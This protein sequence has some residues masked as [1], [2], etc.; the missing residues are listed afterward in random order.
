M[1]L[2][3]SL[4]AAL[5]LVAGAALADAPAAKPD[6]RAACGGDVIRLCPLASA[7]KDR[8]ECMKAHWADI[9]PTCKAAIKVMQAEGAP[10][11]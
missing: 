11:P 8:R 7:G 2:A 10:K 3:L 1:K 5:T 6:M 4:A 9:S